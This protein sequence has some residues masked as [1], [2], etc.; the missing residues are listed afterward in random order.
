MRKRDEIDSV[1]CCCHRRRFLTHAYR[2]YQHNYQQCHPILPVRPQEYKDREKKKNAF[3]PL[4]SSLSELDYLEL[5]ILFS[6]HV[7]QVDNYFNH[8][9]QSCN[10][11]RS[12]S[13]ETTQQE[14]WL[15]RLQIGNFK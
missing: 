4:L 6:E 12:S 10:G 14:G 1:H 11:A 15:S 13:D 7:V 5:V 2:T 8:S 9:P 3:I